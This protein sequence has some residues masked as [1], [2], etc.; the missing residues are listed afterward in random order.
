MPRGPV[1]RS[2]RRARSTQVEAGTGRRARGA[3]RTP[4]EAIRARPV[5][6][7]TGGSEPHRPKR[8]H[9]MKIHTALLISALAWFGLSTPQSAESAS[10]A[11]GVPGL[12]GRL[13]TLESGV[14][15]RLDTLE[16]AVTEQGTTGAALQVTVDD[17]QNQ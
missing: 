1:M 12:T 17:L 5:D 15:N 4:A 7:L 3:P 16:S 9:A 13:D 14:T 10:Q 6:R 8:R 2:R 11:G